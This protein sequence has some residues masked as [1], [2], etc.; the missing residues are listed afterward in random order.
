MQTVLGATRSLIFCGIAG[1]TLF[2][3]N[4]IPAHVLSAAGG[5]SPLAAIF[6]AVTAPVFF[7]LGALITKRFGAVAVL[8]VTYATLAIPFLVMGPPHPYKPLIAL[9][10]GLAYDIGMLIGGRSRLRG[11][12]LGFTGFTAVSLF[13]Y[14]QA[15]RILDLPGREMLEEWVFYFAA[16]FLLIGYG[17]TWISSQIYRKLE[18]SPAVRHIQSEQ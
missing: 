8:Y 16:V 7:A 18:Q 6:G 5:G 2:G 4:F 14:L 12:L 11:L 9:C 17:M 3:I 13:L 10:A 15:F 1:A